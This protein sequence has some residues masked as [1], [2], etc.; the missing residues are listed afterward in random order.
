MASTRPG[1][2]QLECESV[3]AHAI[4]GGVATRPP[5]QQ[6]EGFNPHALAGLEGRRA[7]ADGGDLAAHLVPGADGLRR[8]PSFAAI[9]PQ[10]RTADPGRLMRTSTPPGPG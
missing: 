8:V 1:C 3:F 10:I 6:V 4:P 2:Y 5:P 7:G 9:V